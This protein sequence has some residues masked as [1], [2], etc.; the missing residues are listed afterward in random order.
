MERGEKEGYI[1]KKRNNANKTTNGYGRKLIK[2][3][4]R[5]R[6]ER[7]NVESEEGRRNTYVII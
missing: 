7:S 2:K 4:R 5:K 3:Q 1:E 6:T